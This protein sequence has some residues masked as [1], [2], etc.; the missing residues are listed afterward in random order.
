MMVISTIEYP[1]FWRNTLA[2]I[3]SLQ[4]S[5]TAVELFGIHTPK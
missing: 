4:G 2:D 3:S 1:H 5:E